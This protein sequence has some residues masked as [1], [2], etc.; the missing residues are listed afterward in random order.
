MVFI[1]GWGGWDAT[2]KVEEAGAGFVGAPFFDVGHGF[3]DL[4]GEVGVAVT[5][6]SKKRERVEVFLAL[7][8][9]IRLAFGVVKG[10]GRI[11]GVKAVLKIG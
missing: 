11:I 10:L 4:L 5:A 7:G 2:G 3:T 9:A 1:W 8:E 6:F